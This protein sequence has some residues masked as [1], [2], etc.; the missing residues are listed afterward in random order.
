MAT[1]NHRIVDRTTG[2]IYDVDP[3]TGEATEMITMTVPVGTVCYTPKQQEAHRDKRQR[4]DAAYWNKRNK[5]ALGRFFFVPE[6]QQFP[7]LSPESVTRLIYLLTYMRFKDNSLMVT[8]R[9]PM[10][11]KDLTA[12]LRISKATVTRFWNEVSQDY[13]TK[14]GQKNLIVKDSQLICGYLKKNEFIPYQQFYIDGVRRLYEAAAVEDH[15]KIGVLF[16][17]LP[18][19]NREY[20]LLCVPECVEET[21]LNKIELL[22]IRDFC[23][24]IQYSIGNIWRLLRSFKKISFNVDG[25]EEYF[26]SFSFDG[27]DK[28]D[29]KIFVNPHIF[30][31]GSDYKRV[32]VLGALCKKVTEKGSQKPITAER[33]HL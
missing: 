4:E 12:V 6:A 17:L 15:G 10:K 19:I 8:E 27:I 20:N 16:K 25:Q 23:E 3:N 29:A 32:E 1:L 11:R 14:D 22:S 9:T 28:R 5:N 33:C 24:L 31:V 18:F 7:G 13:I 26:C 2:K 30:Y 21:E